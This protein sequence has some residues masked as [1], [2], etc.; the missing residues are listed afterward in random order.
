MRL[1]H[2][3]DVAVRR[4]EVNR[5]RANLDF[6]QG[7]YATSHLDQATNWAKRKAMMGS[8]RAF[9]NAFE[10]IRPSG[11]FKVLRFDEPNAEW[12]DF[13]CDCRRG[14]NRYREH[15][16][17]IGG[18]ADDKV[19]YAVDMYYQGLWDMEATLDALR[20]YGVND[21]WCFVSQSAVDELL[22]YIDSWEV[23]L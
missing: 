18:V 12:V 5:S 20:F 16:L 22:S 7:F 19:Y 9:V 6:G 8:G 4:P 10:L 23:E 11:K 15:D 21:Q 1:Y 14:S 17:I 3:S 13:V 2:G